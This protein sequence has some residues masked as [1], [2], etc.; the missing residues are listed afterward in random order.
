MSANLR[1]RGRPVRAK[2]A[3]T[4]IELL[5]V[6]GIV[7]ILI[8]LLLPTLHRA[9]QSAHAIACASNLRQIGIALQNYVVESHGT[10]FWRGENLDTDGMDWYA[11]GGR[12]TGNLNLEPQNYFNTMIPRPLNRFAGNKIE[13]FH[14]PDDIFAPWTDNPDFTAYPAPSQFEW[15]GNSYNFNANGYP[16]RPQP[17]HDGGLDGVRFSSIRDSS[18]TIT[19]FEAAQYWG[20]T[21]H[22]AHKGNVCFADGHV[23]FILMPTQFGEYHWDP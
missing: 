17:R 13:V 22:F 14:C 7:A 20:Y 1:I 6:I 23:S 4:L 5:V 10:I 21:W 15:V 9:R 2:R 18:R 16:L 3:F 12:E 19:F 8:A 11:F